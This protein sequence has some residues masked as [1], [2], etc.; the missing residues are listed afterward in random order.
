ML[1]RLLT[2]IFFLSFGTLSA[3]IKEP[4]MNEKLSFQV[5]GRT[6]TITAVTNSK[7]IAITD[8][9]IGH[10][11]GKIYITVQEGT[12]GNIVV[13]VFTINSS[14]TVQSTGV[15]ASIFLDGTLS[16]DWNRVLTTSDKFIAFT[17]TTNS[18][19]LQGLTIDVN[20]R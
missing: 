1:N 10:K 20:I 17:V 3:Q 19:D 16:A 13:D 15:S 5:F 8:D 11:L 6:E 9:M 4:P 18:S 14:N 7:L 12:T 2:F